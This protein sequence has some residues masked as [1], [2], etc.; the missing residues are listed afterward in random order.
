M[1]DR[2]LSPQAGR[3]LAVLPDQGVRTIGR[4]AHDAPLPSGP[5][6]EAALLELLKADALAVEQGDMGTHERVPMYLRLSVR[7]RELKAALRGS[8]RAA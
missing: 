7:G 8:R 3:L 1:T 5:M 6:A 4:A 2:P